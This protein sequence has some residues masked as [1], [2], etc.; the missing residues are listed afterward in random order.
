MKR[1]VIAI[2]MMLMGLA[3]TEL[4]AAMP[5]MEPPDSCEVCGMS[6]VEYS[7]SR[8]LVTY[9]DGHTCGTCSIACA[10]GQLVNKNRRI[11][12]VQVGD[13]GTTKLIDAKKARWVL[14]SKQHGVMSTAATWAFA[15]QE[16]ADAYIKMYGGKCVTWDAVLATATAH[17]TGAGKNISHHNNKAAKR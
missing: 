2:I 15:G 4:A 16:G 10:I 8:I 11:K 5:K 9:E 3:A 13:Y 1:L 17:Q 12:S 14:D 6:R 7:Y